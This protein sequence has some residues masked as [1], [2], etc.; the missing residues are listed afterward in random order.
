MSNPLLVSLSHTCTHTHT[1][2]LYFTS[3]LHIPASECFFVF[4][5]HLPLSFFLLIYPFPVA[6]LLYPLILTWPVPVASLPLLS[7]ALPCFH[8]FLIP[9]SPSLASSLA[10]LSSPTCLL[11]PLDPHLCPILSIN[12]SPLGI[13]SCICHTVFHPLSCPVSAMFGSSQCFTCYFS[14]VLPSFFTFWLHCTQLC[15]HWWLLSICCFYH[16]SVVISAAPHITTL[17]LHLFL[18]HVCLT[19]IYTDA[20]AGILA[21]QD[22]ECGSAGV[23][24]RAATGTIPLGM[25]FYH[26][27]LPLWVCLLPAPH[28]CCQVLHRSAQ[29][30]LLRHL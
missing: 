20:G 21:V 15:H 30:T 5:L 6:L 26:W 28:W 24:E 18:L 25:V 8:P 23:S 2:T 12:L 9:I 3:C 22:G 19:W 4:S 16:V 10:C 29:A 7:L 17:N 11:C 13:S 27:H 14:S 1:A